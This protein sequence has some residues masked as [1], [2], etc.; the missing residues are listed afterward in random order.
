M[1]EILSTVEA[2]VGASIVVALLACATARTARTR[3][4][5][6]GVLGV[7]FALVI[8]I[9]ATGALDPERAL[10]APAL[11]FTVALPVATLVG[12][13]F[14]VPSIR[15]AM[16]A[17]PLPALIAVNAFRVLAGMSFVILYA[18]GRLPA[19]FAPSAGWGDIFVGL[20]ALP[21]A[22]SIARFGPRVRALAL[23]W[24][25][26]GF[27]DLVA[28]I[29]FGALSAPGPL[30]VFLGPPDSALMTTLPWLIIPEF[31]VPS[32]IFIHVVIFYRLNGAAGSE[33]AHEWLAEHAAKP[34]SSAHARG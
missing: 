27:V 14:A 7:W 20:T 3:L 5:A 4:F 10:G 26:I 8:A 12:A 30:Q 15:N 34:T 9:G 17:T 23:A 25:A 11:G 29:A 13:F 33:R 19:P 2:T 18:A 24:N 32:L 16:L 31:I 22:W 6:A 28:A 1:F 21:L